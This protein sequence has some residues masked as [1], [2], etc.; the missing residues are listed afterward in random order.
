MR[1]HLVLKHLVKTSRAN[2]LDEMLLKIITNSTQVFEFTHSRPGPGM[3][4]MV[5]VEA[6]LYRN[7]TLCGFSER[8][9]LDVTMSY[10]EVQESLR[11]LSNAGQILSV[12]PHL[13]GDSNSYLYIN[14][15][16]IAPP[17]DRE[18]E[19]KDFY[20]AAVAIEDLSE[21]LKNVE[22]ALRSAGFQ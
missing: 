9:N 11:R 13:N 2:L 10:Q 16:Y 15:N 22:Q 14:K 21:R 5:V 4:V 8:L 17:V 7:D 3:K 19:L 6:S 20:T 1:N 12:H 18:K